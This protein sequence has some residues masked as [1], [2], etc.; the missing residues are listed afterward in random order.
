MSD[1]LIQEID[2][3]VQ[4]KKMEELWKKHGNTIVSGVLAIVLGTALYTG[5]NNYTA[6]QQQ[7]MTAA[8][9]MPL[10]E[11]G[12]SED[13]K[14]EDLERFAKNNPG[15]PLAVIARLETAGMAMRDNKEEKAIEIYNALA[16]DTT[17]EPAFR[18]LGELYSVQAQLD[19]G[20]PATLQPRLEKLIAESPWKASAKEFSAFLYLKTGDKAKAKKLFTE[21]TTDSDVPTSIA[22]RATSMAQWLGDEGEKPA[23]NNQ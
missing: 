1:S 11:K 12:I 16:N 2:E 9:I 20:D 22:S 18:Q 14:I 3:E 5:W 8:V 23:V 10:Q 13:K 15:I 6:S 7:R 4:Q 19:K 17:I 21:L